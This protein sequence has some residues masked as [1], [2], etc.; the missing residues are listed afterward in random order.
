MTDN[1]DAPQEPVEKPKKGLTVRGRGTT[2]IIKGRNNAQ[3][4][5]RASVRFLGVN[6][7]LIIG[8]GVNMIDVRILFNGND[9]VIEIGAKCKINGSLIVKSGSTISVGAGT[10]FNSQEARVHCG[11]PGTN[12]VI[13][14]KC[15][16]ASVR[17]RTS[18]QHAIYDASTDSRINSARDIHVEDG[19]WIAENVYV[20][21]GVTIGAG[22]VVGARSTVLK[23]LP[24]GCLCVG[25]P[26][27]SVREGIYWKDKID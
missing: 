26:A 24:G 25:T 2:N 15:L 14:K 19:V 27:Q 23:S 17:F 5:K 18:D 6:N 13:G 7:T 12:I 9:S 22:S 16:L 20:Y 3:V 1:I 4:I 8:A 11:E 21:K 10:K